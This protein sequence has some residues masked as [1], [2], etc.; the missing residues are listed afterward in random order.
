[1]KSESDV[2][3]KVILPL[4][5]DAAPQGLGIPDSWISTKVSIKSITIDKGK[6]KKNYFPDFVVSVYGL[7]VL[8]VEAK[9]PGEDLVEALREARL[10]AA[11]VNAGYGPD[12]DPVKFVIA[13]DGNRILAGWSNS[14]SPDFDIKS[15]RWTPTDTEYSLFSEKYSSD[16]LASWA[17]EVLKELRPRRYWK[18]RKLVGGIA[19]QEE[20]VGLNSFGVTIK[21]DFRELF[22]PETIDERDVIARECY[23]PSRRRERYVDS[24]DR[25]FKAII[26]PSEKNAKAIDDTSSP[27]E[28]IEKLKYG[29]R[30]KNQVM[31]L[32]GAAGAGKTTF[33]DHLRVKALPS[34]LREGTHWVHINMNVAPVG[35]DEIYPWLRKEIQRG[36]ES[37][38]PDVNFKNIRTIRKIFRRK[39]SEFNEGVGSL[40]QGSGE[41]YNEKLADYISEFLKDDHFVAQS[42]CS[43]V[44][45]RKSGLVVIALDNCDKRS[46]DEQ[47]LMFEA[48]QWIRNEF[49][50]MVFLPLRE[51]T[52]DNNLG[53]PPLDTALKDMSFRIEPPRFDLIL[54]SRVDLA[55]S[56]LEEDPDRKFS[57]DL[58]N[59]MKVSYTSED[60]AYYL[61]SILRS[62]FDTDASVRR[63]LIGLSGRNMRRAME[64]F[65]DFC[66]SGHISEDEIVKIVQSRGEYALPMSMV[67]RVILRPK[68]RYY[69]SDTSYVV[70][71]FSADIDDPRPN[72]F[73]RVG[74]LRYLRS[75]G[76]IGKGSRLSKYAR[77][78]DIYDALRPMGLEEK[79]FTRELNYLVR[80]HCVVSEDF[81]MSDVSLDDLVT[82]G[83]A[84]RTHIYLMGNIQ[85]ISAVSE[86]TWF[87]DQSL[88]RSIS[89]RIRN[90]A[91]QFSNR[92]VVQNAGAVADFLRAQS[93]EVLDRIELVHKDSSLSDLISTS[94]LHAVVDRKEREHLGAWAGVEVRFLAGNVYDGLVVG[95]KNFGVF[96]QLENGVDGM[97]HVS[98]LLGRPSDFTRGDVV[99]VKIEKV[100][101]L[102]KKID[103]ALHSN[104]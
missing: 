33:V 56:K 1:M 91:S 60:K 90:H 93:E 51:E 8:I 75:L 96:V 46:M 13:C 74:I 68:K 66:S 39:I 92:T 71:L 78:M 76:E 18:P 86:D 32:I 15:E 53:L 30:L 5:K 82:I 48:A 104:S 17:L 50:A 55:I 67:S 57:Y 9:A 98:N 3:Q 58:P 36:A 63:L 29:Q 42:Y 49:D 103:L 28:I 10:Y 95:I 99:S 26:P 2:E 59:A 4:L 38:F 7:P 37:A 62:I 69:D 79:A 20:E 54:R 21:S 43:Y 84:G 16:K 70:N 81:R 89:D 41:K 65:L 83:P 100:D 35:R 44:S 87:R 85:Y 22:N 45:S 73:V 77:A 72:F 19:A 31:L 34:D 64:I 88:A 27:D 14:A 12:V 47:L 40:Y 101:V 102:G 97:I 25:T 61:T 52:Y 94:N 24:I 6:S 11:E 80:S 23:I